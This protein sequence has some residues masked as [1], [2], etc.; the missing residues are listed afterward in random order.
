V[1]KKWKSET[2]QFQ[3]GNVKALVVV[4]IVKI[5]SPEKVFDAIHFLMETPQLYKNLS[6]LGSFIF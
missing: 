4:I 6:G 1:E 2:L 3:M 5:V